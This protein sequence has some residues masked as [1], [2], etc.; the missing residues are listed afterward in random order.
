MGIGDSAGGNLEQGTL[1]QTGEHFRLVLGCGG[2]G[3]LALEPGIG[4]E[5]DGELE[6]EA[7]RVLLRQLVEQLSPRRELYH[8]FQPRRNLNKGDRYCHIILHSFSNT[9]YSGK[10]S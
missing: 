4:H 9:M 2:T 7:V 5:F 1:D 6:H 10:A 3:Y 8:L